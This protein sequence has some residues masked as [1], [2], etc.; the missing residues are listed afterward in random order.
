M[1]KIITCA[2]FDE[3][4]EESLQK[5]EAIYASDGIDS[6]EQWKHTFGQHCSRY[7]QL[8]PGLLIK[9]HQDE[10][11][12]D[13]G[14]KA[15]HSECFPIKLG[16]QISGDYRTLNRGMKQ[17]YYQEIGG[18][19]YLFFNP[20]TEEIEEYP[21]Q[22]RILRVRVRLEPCFLRT[23]SMGQVD[24]LPRELQPLIEGDMAPLFHRVVGKITPEMQLALHQILNCP[25]R[26]LMRRVYLEGKALELIALQFDRLVRGEPKNCNAHTLRASDTDRI[27][28]AKDILLQKLDSPPSVLELAQQVGLNRRKLTEGFH[29]V[30]GTTPFSCLRNYRLEK[31][32]Q[33]LSD[34]EASV[35]AVAEAVGYNDRSY[36]AAAFRK[37]FGINPK[38][39]QLHHQKREI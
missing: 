39:Y 8:H 24:L 30:F 17:D 3:L 32:Q 36:F 22:K 12:C 19:N 25:Y 4:W 5:G 15:L 20:N 31:A 2:E 38:T 18:E 6:V 37:K 7:I 35:E 34:P 21:A 26:R 10:S 33:L 9:I 29:Q 16:F 1:M 14:L 11:Q 13:W 28:H 27:H 23:L